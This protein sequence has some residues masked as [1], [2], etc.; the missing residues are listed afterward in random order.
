MK[1]CF[2]LKDTSSEIYCHSRT[3]EKLIKDAVKAG[4]EDV[5]YT[6]IA[7]TFQKGK[8]AAAEQGEQKCKLCCLT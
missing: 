8:R 4:V 1:H 5:V 7:S 2:K 3:L 6:A